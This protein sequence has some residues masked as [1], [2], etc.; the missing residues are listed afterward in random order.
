MN[1]ERFIAMCYRTKTGRGRIAALSSQAS[2]FGAQSLTEVRTTV[3]FEVY[4]RAYE[5]LYADLRLRILI[6]MDAAAFGVRNGLQCQFTD[7]QSANATFSC[8]E[9]DQTRR[10]DRD[11]E[12]VHGRMSRSTLRTNNTSLKFSYMI[13]RSLISKRLR[14]PQVPQRMMAEIF[15]SPGT[16]P[17]C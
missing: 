8:P 9:V 4:S 7:F 2:R 5:L 12:E 1:F 11:L 15:P 13:V 17:T 6:Q 16:R 14:V 10:L 3:A